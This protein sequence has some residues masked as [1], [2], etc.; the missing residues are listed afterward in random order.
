MDAIGCNDAPLQAAMAL[1]HNDLAKMNSF[2]ELGLGLIYFAI[3][4][5]YEE[6]LP[7]FIPA[8]NQLDMDISLVDNR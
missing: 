2:E 1:V 6:A 4:N 7:L 3:G 8:N 5:L